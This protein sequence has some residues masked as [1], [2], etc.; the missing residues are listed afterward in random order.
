MSAFY[1][2]AYAS[3]SIPAVIAGVVVTDLGLRTTFEVFGAVVAGIALVV[4]AEAY[5]TRPCRTQV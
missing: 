5:R 3:L 4:A 2:A 1:V